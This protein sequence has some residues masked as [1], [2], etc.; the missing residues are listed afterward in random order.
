MIE[1]WFFVH[2]LV[3]LH[4]NGKLNKIIINKKAS[5]GFFLIEFL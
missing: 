5:I 3:S 1:I 4:E 2:L